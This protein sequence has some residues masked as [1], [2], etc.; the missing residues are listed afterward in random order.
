MTPPHANQSTPAQPDDP[1]DLVARFV[2]AFNSGSAEAIDRLYD[3][4]GLVVPRPGYPARD[5]ARMAASRHL[6]SFGAPISA[7][8]R[9]LYVVGDTALIIVDWS[10]HGVGPG[11]GT[12]DLAGAAADVARRGPDG[13]WRYLIDNPFGT[14]VT[15]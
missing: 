2:T 12:V 15:T 13:R 7:D 11:G 8:V 3:D 1:A 14:S 9:Q 10:I 4:A 6:L 5:A